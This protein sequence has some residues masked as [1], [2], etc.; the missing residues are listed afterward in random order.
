MVGTRIKSYLFDKSK[1]SMDEAKSWFSSHK[2]EELRASIVNQPMYEFY[3]KVWGT[4]DVND[5]PDS[6]FAYVEPG[7]K[8]SEGKTVP[9]GKRHLPY[10]NASGAIDSAHLKNALSRL[11]Q[12][13]INSEAKAKAKSKLCSAVSQ[14]NKEHPNQKIQSGVCS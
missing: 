6:S 4:A 10:K 14:W 1:W 2:K 5:Y 8:D 12:T 7:E 3:A 9:R 11:P 13:H